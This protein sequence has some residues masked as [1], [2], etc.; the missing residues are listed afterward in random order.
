MKSYDFCVRVS[1]TRFVDKCLWVKVVCGRESIRDVEQTSLAE[2][3][4]VQRVCNVIHYSLINV[5]FLSRADGCVVFFL[6][7]QLI[8]QTR[9]SWLKL[10]SLGSRTCLI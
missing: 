5:Q 9:R 4:V 2:T 6:F 8:G 7:M 1:L 10:I 3:S